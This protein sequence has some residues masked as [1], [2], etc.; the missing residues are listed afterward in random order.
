MFQ[1]YITNV[2]DNYYLYM[3][4]QVAMKE[5]MCCRFF[6]LQRKIEGVYLCI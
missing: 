5:V 1:I 3:V 2:T 6:V 4:L